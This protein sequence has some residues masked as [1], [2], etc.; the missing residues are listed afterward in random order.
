MLLRR[1]EPCVNFAR[2]RNPGTNVRAATN[3]TPRLV[4]DLIVHS[5]LA[6]NAAQAGRLRHLIEAEAW[7]DVAL[8]LIEIGL[9]EWRL[10]RTVFDDGQWSCALSRHWQVPE[11]LDAPVEGSHE[12]LSLAMLDAFANASLAEKR[13]R[14]CVVPALQPRPKDRFDPVCCDNLC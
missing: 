2:T 11:W 14:L 10:V 7:T 9:P 12:T 5:A 4:A 3:V 6:P 13:T 1:H 8:M